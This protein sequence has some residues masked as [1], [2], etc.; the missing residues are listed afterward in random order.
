VQ[1][2]VGTGVGIAVVLATIRVGVAV[3]PGPETAAADTILLLS[4]S[5]TSSAL[6]MRTREWQRT[7]Q[8]FGIMVSLLIFSGEGKVDKNCEIHPL[9]SLLYYKD[10]VV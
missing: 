2:T 10:A 5:V 7:W 3:R 4:T 8:D 9:S 1:V 6:T